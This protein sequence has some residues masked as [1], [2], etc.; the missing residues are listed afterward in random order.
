MIAIT[1]TN[2][3]TTTISTNIKTDAKSLIVV[4]FGVLFIHTMVVFF[5]VGINS[6]LHSVSV[7]RFP[8]FRTQTLDNPSVDSVKQWIPEQPRPWRTSCERESCHGDRV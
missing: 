5:G 8:S 4:V 1:I 6:A 7:T 3:T 2:N